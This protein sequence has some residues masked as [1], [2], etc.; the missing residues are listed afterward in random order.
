MTAFRQS[1]SSNKVIYLSGL[2]NSSRTQAFGVPVVIAEPQ[3]EWAKAVMDQ[4]NELVGLETGWD[5]YN[6]PPPSFESASFALKILESICDA[7]APPPQIVPGVDRDLQMEWHT[8][9]GD[10]E[11]HVQ[12]AYQVHAWR[13]L[14][15]EGAPE[16]EFD[17]TNDFT[18]I[19]GWIASIAETHVDEAAAA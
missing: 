6:A 15:Y 7:S 5:G 19:A 1:T 12:G 16:E 8:H 11:I 14:G 4:L 2:N 9:A 10:I 18:P 13:R 3:W 17:L